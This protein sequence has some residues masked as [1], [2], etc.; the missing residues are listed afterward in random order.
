MFTRCSLGPRRMFVGS[1]AG[2]SIDARRAY[3]GC[4]ADVR[5]SVECFF[6]MMFEGAGKTSGILWGCLG[7]VSG[8]F[9]EDFGLS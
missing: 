7:D 6:L 9:W 4:S 8:L 5:L 1:S 2:G 3:D